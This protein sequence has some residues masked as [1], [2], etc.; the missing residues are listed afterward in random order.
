MC[1]VSHVRLNFRVSQATFSL[2]PLVSASQTSAASK[3]YD[4]RKQ[5]SQ[6]S[7]WVGK[8]AVASAGFCRWPRRGASRLEWGRA[9]PNVTAHCDAA[10]TQSLVVIPCLLFEWRNA[11]CRCGTAYRSLSFMPVGWRG[12]VSSS[13]PPYQR[14]NSEE[15]EMAENATFLATIAVM[16]LVGFY[17]IAN[18][19]VTQLA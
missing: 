5:N 10:R 12:V 2:S 8:A 16:F 4:S 11:R 17:E 18:F 7:S 15:E 13:R 19:A 14:R 9:E 1:G 6:I 3:F